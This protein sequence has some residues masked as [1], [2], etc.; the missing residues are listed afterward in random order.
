MEWIDTP[1]TAMTSRTPAVLKPTDINGPMLHK[2]ITIPSFPQQFEPT[3]PEIIENVREAVQKKMEEEEEGLKNEPVENEV[4][5][6]DQEKVE[7]GSLSSEPR[8]DEE[9]E[10]G[11]GEKNEGVKYE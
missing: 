7:D 11:K 5:D 4:E 10:C 8:D 9:E 1:Q 6:P 3:Y 2:T